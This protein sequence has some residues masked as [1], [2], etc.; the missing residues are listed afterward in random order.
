MKKIKEIRQPKLGETLRCAVC[1]GKAGKVDEEYIQLFNRSTDKGKKNLYD[2]KYD[3]FLG[4]DGCEEGWEE[5][6]KRYD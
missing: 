3:L 2:A 4:Y 1:F 6:A 5:P